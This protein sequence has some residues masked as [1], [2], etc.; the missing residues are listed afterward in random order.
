MADLSNQI[1][2]FLIN[3]GKTRNEVDT[4]FFSEKIVL[5]SDGQTVDIKTWIV[6]GI[7]KPSTDSLNAF[8]AEATSFENTNKVIK[9]RI[10]SYPLIEDQLDMQYWDNIN[11]TTKWKD[12]I[13][14]IKNDNP[15][16]S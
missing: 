14:K 2:A 5:E 6:S 1:K 3:K 9:N 4:L 13:T 10:K 12:L 15:K 7:S 8:D 16:P 11:G